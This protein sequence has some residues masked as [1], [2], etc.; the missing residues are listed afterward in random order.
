MKPSKIVY[1]SRAGFGFLAA[2]LCTLLKLDQADNPL[3]TGISMALILYIITYYILKSLFAAK[4]EKKSKIV[5]MGVG[6]YFLTWII[7]WVLLSTL[8]HPVA[9]FTHSPELPTVGN[10]VTFDAT[11]SYDMTSYIVSYKWIFGDGTTAVYLKDMN[12]TAITTHVYADAG[13]YEVTLT[14]EDNEGYTAEIK[15]PVEVLAQ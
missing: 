8:M 10:T 6:I 15:K 9:A 4:V 3:L 7:T 5:T 2:L 12:L 11:E 1:W 13:D 14:V